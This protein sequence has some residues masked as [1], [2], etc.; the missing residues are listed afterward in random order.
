MGGKKRDIQEADF[1]HLKNA[2]ELYLY[3]AKTY[4]HWVKIECLDRKGK[5]R[6]RKDIHKEV[7][8]VL[9][10]RKII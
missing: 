8:E 10:K 4:K 3:L 5:L 7:I 1:A 9:K 2:E 6:S